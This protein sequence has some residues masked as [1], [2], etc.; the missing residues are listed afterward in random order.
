[1]AV[2]TTSSL[3]EKLTKEYDKKT[4]KGEQL[5]KEE[6]E[7][8]KTMSIA[9]PRAIMDSAVSYTNLYQDTLKLTNMEVNTVTQTN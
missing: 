9:L 7:A 5:N 4:S 6:L 2:E 8:L 3:I 1:M